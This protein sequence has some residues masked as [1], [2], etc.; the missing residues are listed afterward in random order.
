MISCTAQLNTHQCTQSSFPAQFQ[1]N[2]KTFQTYGI[3]AL[4]YML[5]ACALVGGIAIG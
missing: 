5:Q 1:D 2:F 4:L 3:A